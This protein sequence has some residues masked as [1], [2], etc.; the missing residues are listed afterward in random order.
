MEKL[1]HI[2]PGA[3]IST[4]EAKMALGYL[5]SPVIQ[6]E[7]INGKPLVGGFIRVYRH[8]TT[9][10]YITHRD[11]DGDLNPAEVVLD[12]R[13]MCILLAE[14]GGLYD[15]YCEDRERVEQWSRVNVP[16]VGAGGGSGDVS[17]SSSD[18]S[19][20]V[21]RTGNSFDIKVSRDGSA[22]ALVAFSAIRTTD[23]DFE[24]VCTPVNSVGNDLKVANRKIVATR[25]WYHYDATVAL[26]WRGTP[27]NLTRD[28]AI[29]GPANSEHMDFDLSYAHV[30]SIDLS[31]DLEIAQSGTPV[32]F[33]VQGLPEGMRAQVVNASVHALVAGGSGG[34]GG[35]GGDMSE[36][37]HDNTLSG[38]GT[39]ES[40]LGVN[41]EWMPT[42]ISY[43]ADKVSGAVNGDLAALDSN[44]NLVDSGVKPSDF[45][46]S[47]QGSVADT[48]IQGVKVNG[49]AVAPDSDRVV[50]ITIP[51]A[52]TVDP[53]Y[54]ASSHNA[55]AGTAVAQAI[56]LVRQV[57]VASSA[58][59]GKVLAV[60]Q[61][62]DPAWANPSFTQQNADWAATS[63]VAEILN[64]PTEDI[65]VAGQNVS[66]S[67]S[68]GLVTVSAV[69]TTYSFSGGLTENNGTVTVDRP[70]PATSSGDSGKVL[71][72]TDQ[73][74]SLGWVNQ[75][76][77]SFPSMTGNAGK[78]LKVNQ[79]A[80]GVEWA[81]DEDTTYSFS[82][83]LTENNGTVTV[84]RPVPATSS[85]DSGKVLGVTDQ[86]GTLGWVNQPSSAD[87]ADKV[88]GATAGN[89]AG[90]NGGGNLVDSGYAPSDF[91]TSAQG[92]KADS[93][94]QGVNVNGTAL[95][96]D[97]SGTVTVTVDQNYASSSVN[98]QSGT[99]VAQA[100]SSVPAVPAIASTD[101][102]KVLKASYN[103]GTTSYS[104]QTEGGGAQNVVDQVY[105][106]VS[107]NAQ[108]G[109]AVA[110]AISGVRQVPAASSGDSGKVLGVTDQNGTLGWVSNSGGGGTSYTAGNM[111]SLAGDAI[112]VVTTAGVTDIQRVSELPSN[113]VATVIYLVPKQLGQGRAIVQY[114]SLTA[115]PTAETAVKLSDDPNV[116]EI[117][118]SILRSTGS[119]H[120]N[121]TAVLEANLRYLTSVKFPTSLTSVAGL[122]NTSSLTDLNSAFYGCASLTSVQTFS[123]SAVTNMAAMFYGCT[124][125]AS[126]PLFDTSSVVNFG[127][128]VNSGMFYGCSSLTTVPQFN[129]SS[130]QRFDEVFRGCSSLATMPL[131]DLSSCTT[132]QNA[133]RDCTSLATAPGFDLSSAANTSH[134]FRGCSSL[135]AVPLFDLSSAAN[136]SSMFL[137][138]TAVQSGALALYQ[139]TST[140]AVPP[141]N[142]SYM[143]QDCGS[144]TVTGAAE[145]A[146]IPAAWGGTGA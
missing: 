131:L 81:D 68:G 23:G 26:D 79:G 40:P 28:I 90:L 103:N 132:T 70:V 93:A 89:L 34:G 95:T 106:P 11:F 146:Q 125:L 105:N 33:A 144:G 54:S 10:P 141:T 88:S 133:F 42:D 94:I 59:N 76:S 96:P 145:L 124:S 97:A 12:A 87:K 99:A 112:S 6:V 92:S 55:Q 140:Q 66:I 80:T 61:H 60:D 51:P 129:T 135:T 31:G 134:M 108:S 67:A 32:T 130:A 127:S 78:V 82:G 75:S 64:K 136:T 52:V 113:P 65:L 63:G 35:G 137:G 100:I 111:V 2:G 120:G 56:D 117:P 109:T 27:V 53:D 20:T 7:D 1:F 142:F 102:G 17:I 139:R 36:V 48:A 45:A 86:N 50:S 37:I 13:G 128:G 21:I 58:D 119:V 74:G 98:A 18:G 4:Q 29:T 110:G 14:E 30:E 115:Y 16:V 22:S 24:F 5:V 123:T 8:G 77:A 62:G 83:G 104:W 9:D 85:V 91:A 19:I 114:S 15:I 43:K 69:D 57:P 84:D 122:F 41:P 73:N 116:W 38:D 138:C 39:L 3:L 143:F 46:S 25:H 44:G 71:G 118:V 72:V 47:A 121:P 49:S 126:V 101:D 107:T